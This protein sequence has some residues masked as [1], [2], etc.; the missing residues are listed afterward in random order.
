MRRGSAVWVL[1][2]AA[3][4]A[5]LLALRLELPPYDDAFFFKRFAL[6]F[7]DRGAFAW[8]VADGPVHGNTSQLFQLAVTGLSIIDRERVITLSRILLAGGLLSGAA[9]LWRRAESDE[10]RLPIALAFASPV[11]LAAALSGMETGLV[12]GLEGLLLSALRRGPAPSAAL[13][14]LLYL[15]RPDTALLSL[16]ALALAPWPLR[17]RAGALVAAAAGIG[18]ALIALKGYYGT[19]LP[20]SFYVKS[21]LS[22]LYDDSY[23]LARSAAA[24]RRHFLYFLVSAAPLAAIA[25]AGRRWRLLAPAA[26]FVGYHL[27]FTVDVMGLHGRFF[28]PAL[29]PLAAAAADGIGDWRRLGW[30]T[31]ALLSAAL[32][33]AVAAGVWAGLLPGDAGWSIGRVHP[34]VYAGAVLAAAALLLRA[35]VAPIP[36]AAAIW[37]A[38]AGAL[39][40]AGA[41]PAR[42]VPGD[43]ALAEALAAEVSSWRG[44]EQLARCLGGRVHL[45]HS[46]IG[47]PGQ[48]LPE[49]RITDLGGL[50]SPELTLGGADFETICRRDRPEAIFLPHRNYRVLNAQIRAGSCISGYRR[51]TGRG[52]S[53]LFIRADKIAQFRC[54]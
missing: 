17:R 3:L 49:A 35:P 48:R 51:V 20:L 33:A 45:Y 24:R 37:G 38:V 42:Q 30:R 11:A 41:R 23:F 19:A 16:G 50:M 54:R 7:L 29:P 2:Y 46:E 8:N 22:G 53:P 6:N 4:L 31:P 40:L 9:A 25:A 14:V 47:V 27:L 12:L 15:A 13:A 36:R 52:S 5:L 44:L 34:A 28:A 43:E 1:G 26:L 10:A 21:G 39:L 32:A 18:A